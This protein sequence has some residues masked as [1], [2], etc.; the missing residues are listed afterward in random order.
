MSVLSQSVRPSGEQYH[1][2]D[3]WKGRGEWKSCVETWKIKDQWYDREYDIV[4]DYSRS[5][6]GEKGEEL[7]TRRW[8]V[9]IREGTMCN[10]VCLADLFEDYGRI[11]RGDIVIRRWNVWNVTGR[12]QWMNRRPVQWMNDRRESMTK[13]VLN[14]HSRLFVTRVY[15]KRSHYLMRRW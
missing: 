3:R 10:I 4:F 5:E 7:H 9:S 6:R 8:L 11:D 15:E 12:R 2:T 1:C 14:S 13:C